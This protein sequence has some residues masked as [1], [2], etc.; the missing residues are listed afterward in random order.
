MNFILTENQLSQIIT[1]IKESRL[2]GYMKTLNSFSKEIISKTQRVYGINLKFLS[3]WGAAI[4]GL[5]MPLDNWIRTNNFELNDDQIALILIGV[6][7]TFFFENKKVLKEVLQKIKEEGIQKQFT[8]TLNKG[9]E[10]KESFFS[11]LYSLNL[12]FSEMVEMVSYAFLIPIVDDLVKLSNGADLSST[13]ELVS[14]RLLASGAIILTGNI[15]V[16]VIGKI[17]KR[18]SGK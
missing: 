10:L 17:L 1:E 12:T 9:K 13:T 7:C 18:F 4:G 15:L 16:E 6:T 2:T 14:E 8:K 5:A 3:K 11:F